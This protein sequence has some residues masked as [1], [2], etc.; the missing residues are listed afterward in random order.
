MLY[1]VLIMAKCPLCSQRAA[2]RH[3]PAK[4][5]LICPICCGT[6][7][8]IE[9]DCPSDCRYLQTGRAYESERGGPHR[10]VPDQR[11][12]NEQFFYRNGAFISAVAGVL[13]EERGAMPGLT[14][15]DARD[16]FIALRATMKTLDAGIYYETLPDSGVGSTAV[17][18]RLKGF[19]DESLHSAGPEAVKVSDVLAV[20]DFLLATAEFHSG[21]RPRSRRF[22]D[23]LRGLAPESGKD[24]SSRLIVP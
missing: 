14:D 9:I 23:W 19:F 3:C 15:Q 22:L 8:E 13:L 10:T 1:C 20:L 11:Q 18:R 17:Y 2:K 21:E 7:R 24:E 4:G 16:A 5:Q 6:K 12:F